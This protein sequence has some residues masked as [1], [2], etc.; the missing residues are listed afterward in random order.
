MPHKYLEVRVVEVERE[1]WRWRGR[2]EV[3]REVEREVDKSGTCSSKRAC[4]VGYH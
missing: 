3:E 4:Q 1:G 2:V